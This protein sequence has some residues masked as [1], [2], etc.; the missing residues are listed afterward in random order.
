MLSQQ[1]K[2]ELGSYVDA[3]RTMRRAIEV[4]A[5]FALRKRVRVVDLSQQ[6]TA[7]LGRTYVLLGEDN[8]PVEKFSSSLRAFGETVQLV[9]E[10]FVGLVVKD[11]EHERLAKEFSSA[12]D[13]L[14]EKLAQ[15]VKEVES[16]H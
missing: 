9:E 1:E 12:L 3:L 5:G 8:K 10:Y 14:L 2:K 11:T 6:A 15:G 16:A 13:S 7:D 4:K